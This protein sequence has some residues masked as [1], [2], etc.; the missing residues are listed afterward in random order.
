MA[1]VRAGAD[2]IPEALLQMAE[3]AH[4]VSQVASGQ[5]P[6]FL[7]FWAKAVREPEI[8]QATIAPYR[9]YRAFFADL[10]EAG[11]EE[12][13]LRPVDPKRTAQVIVSL[14]VGL[15]L[16]GMLDPQETDWGQVAEEGVQ[17][18]LEGIKRK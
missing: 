7:E 9:R 2:T 5:I 15:V 4:Q 10:I 6:I 17:T 8:W 16:Q 18:L 13:T 12:G 11:I 3:M 14:A 1:A